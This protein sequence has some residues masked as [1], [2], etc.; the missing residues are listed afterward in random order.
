MRLTFDRDAD[1]FVGMMVG[2]AVGD[3]FEEEL[4]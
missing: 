4:R 3:C 2:D 1:G